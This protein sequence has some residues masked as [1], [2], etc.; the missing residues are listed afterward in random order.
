LKSNGSGTTIGTFFYE[1]KKHGFT[2]DRTHAPQLDNRSNG[3]CEPKKIRNHPE[4]WD[5]IQTPKPG[6]K[7]YKEAT[8][9][10]ISDASPA[11]LQEFYT[12]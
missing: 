2:L 4:S 11:E 5:D 9:A 7:E 10:M 6:S 12:L 8:R 1:C 3:N